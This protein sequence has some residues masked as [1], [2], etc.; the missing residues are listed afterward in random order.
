MEKTESWAEILIRQ[1]IGRIKELEKRTKQELGSSAA[2][3]FTS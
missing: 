2:A 1:T 3:S